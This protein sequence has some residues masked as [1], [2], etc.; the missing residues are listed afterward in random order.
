V[1]ANCRSVVEDGDSVAIRRDAM[2]VVIVGD[3][4][5]QHARLI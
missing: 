4:R 1:A 5:A 2:R 3:G